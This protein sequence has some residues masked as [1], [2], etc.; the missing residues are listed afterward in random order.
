M[1]FKFFWMNSLENV[2]S[3]VEMIKWEM[4]EPDDKKIEK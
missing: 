1:L 3:I 2:F 4:I